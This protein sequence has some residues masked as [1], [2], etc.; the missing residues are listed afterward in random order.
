MV[1]ARGSRYETLITDPNQT[2]CPT[3]F[4]VLRLTLGEDCA[5][6]AHVFWVKIFLLTCSMRGDPHFVDYE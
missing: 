1:W 5:S 6:L 2:F 3:W 4:H